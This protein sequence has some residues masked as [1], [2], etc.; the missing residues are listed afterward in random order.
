[1]HNNV[2]SLQHADIIKEILAVRHEINDAK[3]LTVELSNKVDRGVN[4][5]KST[6]FTSKEQITF[7][8]YSLNS[9]MN[10]EVLNAEILRNDYAQLSSKLLK[11]MLDKL[12]NQIICASASI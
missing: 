8:N 4:F 2:T 12:E 10:N 11:Q 6:Y 1:M 7:A 3:N 5:E 9:L